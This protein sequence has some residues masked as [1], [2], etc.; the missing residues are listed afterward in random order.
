MQQILEGLLALVTLNAPDNRDLNDLSRHLKCGVTDKTLKLQVSV[1]VS[2]ALR[3]LEK[4]GSG[5][6]KSKDKPAKKAQR[7]ESSEPAR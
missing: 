5:K 6:S 7:D 4:A 2:T 1:P 3:H